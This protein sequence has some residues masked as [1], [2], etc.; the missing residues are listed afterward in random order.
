MCGGGHAARSFSFFRASVRSAIS[1]DEPPPSE[2]TVF[3]FSRNAASISSSDASGRTLQNFIFVS[4]N[5]Q[6]LI[7]RHN[8]WYSVHAAPP[9]KSIGLG[10]KRIFRVRRRTHAS[11]GHEAGIDP[12]VSADQRGH[13][14]GSRL[15]SIQSPLLL[16]WPRRQN[17]SKTPY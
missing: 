14:I 3:A 2:C 17:G 8:V 13:G 6:K 7:W 16:G 10:W 15:M 5:P 9:E 11:L 4:E 12:K 1:V